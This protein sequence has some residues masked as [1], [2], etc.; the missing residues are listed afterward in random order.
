[1][2]WIRRHPILTAAIAGAIVGVVQVLIVEIGGLFH[3]NSRAILLLLPSSS[4]GDPAH[5]MSVMQTAFILLVDFAGNALGY[6]LLF[7]APAALAVTILRI[8]RRRRR[9]LRP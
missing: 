4:Q 7:A 8:S 9:G 5:P 2:R 6:A 3:K 1:M